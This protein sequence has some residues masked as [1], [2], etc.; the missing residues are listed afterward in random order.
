MDPFKI[1][2]MLLRYHLPFNHFPLTLHSPGSSVFSYIMI[3]F[4]YIFEHV[5]RLGFLPDLPVLTDIQCFALIFIALP[6]RSS[7]LLDL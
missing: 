1:F 3:F 5:H 4:I 6:E 7:Y 2:H